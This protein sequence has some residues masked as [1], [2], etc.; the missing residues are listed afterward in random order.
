MTRP[1]QVKRRRALASRVGLAL[2]LALM[3]L[4]GACDDSSPTEPELPGLGPEI[5]FLDASLTDLE[6]TITAL[7]EETHA[8]ARAVLPIGMTRFTVAGNALRSI[9]GWGMGGY[10]L[11]PND[12][13]LAFDP[14]FPG[15]ASVLE[16]RLPQ[17]VAHELHHTARQGEIGPWGTLLESIVSEGLADHFAVELLGVPLAP[18]SMAFPQSQT[19]RYLE[20]ARPEFDSVRFDFEAWFFGVGT[21]LPVWT[22]YTLGYRI[23]RDY[24]QANPGR[25]AGDLVSTPAD[26]FRP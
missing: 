5:V 13:E 14:E 10:A 12:V 11:S 15:L 25:S 24:Q 7:I 9:P 23:V 16:S 17:L 6:E 20:R 4:A 8:D 3:V 26:A 1:T 21:D 19:S 18:W 2:G 22:G